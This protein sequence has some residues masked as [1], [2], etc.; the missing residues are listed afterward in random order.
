MGKLSKGMLM[1]ALITGCCIGAM[2]TASAAEEPENFDLDE[3]VVTAT[4]TPVKSFEANANV[5][6]VTAKEIETRHYQNLREALKSVPG[7]TTYE[8]G[9]AGYITS[10]ALMINGS[11]K[12]LLLVDGMRMNQGSEINMYQA[13]GDMENIERIEVLHGSASSLY[14]ADA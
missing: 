5:S 14:G 13:F 11:Y 3:I 7:V 12:V 6:V 9:Q 10:D 2:Q 8:Y 1:T 4:R